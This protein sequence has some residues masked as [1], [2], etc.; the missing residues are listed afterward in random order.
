MFQVPW[1]SVRLYF[2]VSSLVL[3]AAALRLRHRFK[4]REAEIAEEIQNSAFEKW[5]RAQEDIL[6]KGRGIYWT[7]DHWKWGVSP[8]EKLKVYGTDIPRERQD[9]HDSWHLNYVRQENLQRDF[10][11][12][13]ALG[14]IACASLIFVIC[15]WSNWLT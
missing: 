6:N 14:I 11:I 5:R 1:H 13:F 12:I 15:N 4:K 8:Q 3:G 10:N 7:E 9:L 2:L